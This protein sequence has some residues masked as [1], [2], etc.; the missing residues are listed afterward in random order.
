MTLDETILMVKYHVRNFF[1]V[2]NNPQKP[3]EPS[4]KYDLFFA[5]CKLLRS[6]MRTQFNRAKESD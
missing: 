5:L 3:P 1:N 4:A 6:T 2:N